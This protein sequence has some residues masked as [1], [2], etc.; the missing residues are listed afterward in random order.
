MSIRRILNTCVMLAMS[1]LVIDAIAGGMEPPPFPP[2]P[3]PAPNY[4]GFYAD[5]YIGYAQTDFPNFSRHSHFTG[6]RNGGVTGGGAGGYQWNRFLAAEVGGI[7][8]PTVGIEDIFIPSTGTTIT[9]IHRKSWFIYVAGKI[10]VP[11]F[12]IDNLDVFFKGGGAYRR[13]ATHGDIIPPGDKPEIDFSS[14]AFQ[15]QPLL[16]TGLQ[17]YINMNWIINFQWMYLPQGGETTIVNSRSLPNEIKRDFPSQSLFT[18]GLELKLI[19]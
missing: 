15:W 18:F 19:I 8:L 3:T 17:Y 1:L 5:G 11:V 14:N 9:D 10:M 6:N 2:Y 12:V 4:I 16:A 13:F 7:S